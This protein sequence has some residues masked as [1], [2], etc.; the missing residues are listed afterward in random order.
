MDLWRTP[1]RENSVR[2]ELHV[3]ELDHW[4][5]HSRRRYNMSQ[6][7][8]TPLWKLDRWILKSSWISQRPPGGGGKGGSWCQ[9]PPSA[10]RLAKRQH[11]QTHAPTNKPHKYTLEARH[12]ASLHPQGMFPM[13]WICNA[14]KK[15]WIA[16]RKLIGNQVVQNEGNLG[17]LTS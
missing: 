15:N 12:S 8:A 2:E 14:I 5:H 13:M 7:W 6:A 9:I 16:G 1:R 17:F 4:Y 11:H 3:E 10:L